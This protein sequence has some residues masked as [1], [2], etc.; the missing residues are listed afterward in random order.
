M[1]VGK[2]A[3]R[4]SAMPCHPKLCA[5]QRTGQPM[6]APKQGENATADPDAPVQSGSAANPRKRSRQCP[7]DAALS[8][9]AFMPAACSDQSAQTSPEKPSKA[10]ESGT[11]ASRADSSSNAPLA[12]LAAI[13]QDVG[14][15]SS[16]S[17]HAADSSALADGA[18]ASVD[19][20][21]SDARAYARGRKQDL[22]GLIEILKS[23]VAR[24]PHEEAI[25]SF[26]DLMPKADSHEDASSSDQDAS[27]QDECAI[28]QAV[29][30]ADDHVKGV[31]S[32]HQPST[33]AATTVSGAGQAS[34]LKASSQ[35]GT[36]CG[37]SDAARES[38]LPLQKDTEAC[39]DTD[40]SSATCEVDGFVVI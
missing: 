2:A 19:H 23:D 7:K 21:A 6:H 40:H 3:A 11:C 8:S 16:S 25:N 14:R 38:I 26:E 18:D 4:V 9:S 15:S 28:I 37:G 22:I 10:S 39:S 33:D 13:T 34:A 24:I 20:A 27:D 5:V 30:D 29:S 35:S 1:R 31:A 12:E 36:A 17:P 32:V